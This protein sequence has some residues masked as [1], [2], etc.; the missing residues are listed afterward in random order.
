MSSQAIELVLQIGSMVILARLLLPEHYGLI[1]M[2]TALV[3]VAARFADLGLE[4]ATIQRKDITHEQVSN[5]FWINVAIGSGLMIVVAAASP[6]IAAFYKETR[7]APIAIAISLNFLM[8]GLTVQHQALLRRRMHFTVLAGIQIGTS[9]L[10]TALAIVLAVA[11]YG[12][13]ALVWR[14]VAKGALMVIAIWIW[15]PWIPDFPNRRVPIGHLLRFARHITGF[16]VVVFATVSLDQILIGRWHGSAEL[17]IYRQAYQLITTP[18]AQLYMAFCRVA[19]PA[20]SSIQDNHERY[21]KYFTKM[22]M[23]LTAVTMPLIL[24]IAIYAE[25][26]VLVM[27]G[28][29]WLGVT[30]VL[31]ILALAVLLMPAIETTGLLLQTTGQTKRYF[32]MGLVTSAIRACAYGIGAWWGALGMAYAHV[33]VTCVAMIPRLYFCVRETPMSLSAFLRAV[34][35]PSIATFGMTIALVLWNAVTGMTGGG[36]RLAMALPIA[37]GAYLLTWMM[38]PGAKEDLREVLGEI[39]SGL[40]VWKVYWKRGGVESG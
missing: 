9:I 5:L 8:A 40:Q 35:K 18:I 37:G 24:F 10:S 36:A 22:L 38:T 32:N 4:Q 15:C 12:Y 1:S 30:E 34:A 16:N 2:V 17:G 13:W 21:R 27:L 39:M 33:A 23:A 14:E 25:D 19:E 20:L 28:K 11:D 31:R 7:L 29:N 3:A 6:L 26:V